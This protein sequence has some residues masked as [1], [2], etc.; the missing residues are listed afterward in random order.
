MKKIVHVSCVMLVTAFVGCATSPFLSEN[1]SER[2]AA[3]NALTDQRKLAEVAL[4]YCTEPYQKL[5]TGCQMDVR[6]RAVERMTDRDLLMAVASFSIVRTAIKGNA[7]H[8][9][10]GEP[11]VELKELALNKLT[12]GKYIQSVIE[13]KDAFAIQPLFKKAMFGY[14]QIA[15]NLPERVE[16]SWLEKVKG[17]ENAVAKSFC[18]CMTGGVSIELC[19]KIYDLLPASV[20]V[21]IQKSIA[22]SYK[23]VV[24]SADNVSDA[25]RAL[26]LAKVVPPVAVDKEG[27]DAMCKNVCTKVSSVSEFKDFGMLVNGVAKQYIS[28]GE[29]MIKSAAVQVV[30]ELNG[31]QELTDFASV[32][33]PYTS[34]WVGQVGIE[35]QVRKCAASVDSTDGVKTFVEQLASFNEVV[36]PNKTD[37]AGDAVIAV[38]EGMNNGGRESIK[39]FGVA[40]TAFPADILSDRAIVEIFKSESIYNAYRKAIRRDGFKENMENELAGAAFKSG[41]IGDLFAAGMMANAMGVDDKESPAYTK[42][43]AHIISIMRKKTSF[44]DAAGY[45]RIYYP[46]NMLIEEAERRMDAV[47]V[48]KCLMAVRRHSSESNWVMHKTLDV[49]ERLVRNKEDEALAL[50]LPLLEKYVTMDHGG[51]LELMIIKYRALSCLASPDRIEKHLLDADVS[52]LGNKEIL[53]AYIVSLKRALLLYKQLGMAEKSEQLTDKVAE[54]IAGKIN[55]DDYSVQEFVFSRWAKPLMIHVAK[56]YP[57]L[58]AEIM[59]RVKLEPISPEFINTIAILSGSPHVLVD[60]LSSYKSISSFDSSKRV[61]RY[62]RDGRWIAY[63]PYSTYGM[64]CGPVCYYDCDWFVDAICE[65]SKF[66]LDTADRVKLNEV[67]KFVAVNALNFETRSRVYE[68][69]GDTSLQEA[70][71]AEWRSRTENIS[72]VTTALFNFSLDDSLSVVKWEKEWNERYANKRLRLRGK[73][74]NVLRTEGRTERDRHFRI[75]LDGGAEVSDRTCVMKVMTKKNRKKCRIDYDLQEAKNQ[76]DRYVMAWDV[77][78]G[79]VKDG[80]IETFVAGE[81]KVKLPI[82]EFYKTHAFCG[83]KGRVPTELI[84]EQERLIADLESKANGS[85]SQIR[86]CYAIVVPSV[87]KDIVES[88]NKGEDVV[89]EAYPQRIFYWDTGRPL[90]FW[91]ITNDDN[92][93]AAGMSCGRIVPKDQL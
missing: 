5:P 9:T 14:Y 18:S 28:N 82:E 67:M 27:I 73:L 52:N 75:I 63:S 58:W 81:G 15:G 2:M 71:R 36:L 11:N 20:S 13:A 90:G 79:R 21:E 65:A 59:K 92:G 44:V 66:E 69:I 50:L 3:V 45:A 70:I 93:F 49:G 88:L 54:Y 38:L 37:I 60:F 55:A 89:F 33:K 77:E 76:L 35:E 62:Q 57:M 4:D 72:Q 23:Q 40:V 68:A 61:S 43:F 8:V 74:I 78:R 22:D 91:G 26:R 25:V 56:R 46:R 10:L 80:K 53:N 86:V 1:A 12:E 6:V 87:Y 47:T 34:T 32:L 42:M 7:C 30:K 31:M 39:D 29:E 24:V 85:T 16:S 17:K 19:K 48:A 84:A 83:K 64:E 51:D 41:S